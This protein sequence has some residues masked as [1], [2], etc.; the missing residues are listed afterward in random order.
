MIV[1]TRSKGG[2]SEIQ[3]KYSYVN[4]ADR[5]QVPGK[6]PVIRPTRSWFAGF[7]PC[8]KICFDS[9]FRHLRCSILCPFFQYIHLIEEYICCTNCWTCPTISTCVSMGVWCIEG[10][11]GFNL[12]RNRGTSLQCTIFVDWRTSSFKFSDLPMLGFTFARIWVLIYAINHILSNWHSCIQC[13]SFFFRLYLPEYLLVT[14]E[15]DI[16][17]IFSCAYVC[18]RLTNSKASYTSEWQF[19]FYVAQ[20]ED[21]MRQLSVVDHLSCE[22]RIRPFDTYLHILNRYNYAVKSNDVFSDFVLSLLWRIRKIQC[23]E[24]TYMRSNCNCNSNSGASYYLT[25]E[26]HVCHIKRQITNEAN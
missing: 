13:D 18:S 26:N 16:K 8:L 7:I 15:S 11:D 23:I 14:M 24:Y 20:C 1:H 25:R 12:Q 4:H 21:G 2:S 19:F 3:I 10:G 9:E 17:L 22:W 6:M 5:E